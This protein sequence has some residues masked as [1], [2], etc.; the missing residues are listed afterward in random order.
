MNIIHPF[1]L[2]FFFLFSSVFFFF[3]EKRL[4]S[5]VACDPIS[6]FRTTLLPGGLPGC[7]PFSDPP[8]PLYTLTFSLQLRCSPLPPHTHAQHTPG[9]P[10]G[11][12]RGCP[13]L[14]PCA[15]VSVGACS[16]EHL[17][18]LALP[19]EPTFQATAAIPTRPYSTAPA[20]RTNVSPAA[21]LVPWHRE[22]GGGCVVVH[23]PMVPRAHT[24]SLQP[25]EPPPTPP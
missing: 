14:P 18:P 7:D 13:P 20:L 24:V 6:D 10:F 3:L 9:W 11:S 19:P 1:F 4:R 8:R 23:M 12:P 16:S 17:H 5:L 2:F 25:F 15:S 21:F 22:S